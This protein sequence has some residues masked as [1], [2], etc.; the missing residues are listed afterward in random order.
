[1]TKQRLDDARLLSELLYLCGLHE[2]W[3]KVGH[4]SKYLL[5]GCF[6]YSTPPFFLFEVHV[7][8]VSDFHLLTSCYWALVG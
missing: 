7:P 4:Y 3:L 6:F 1:M 8:Q 2:W 5:F